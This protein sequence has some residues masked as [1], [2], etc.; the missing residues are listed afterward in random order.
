MFLEELKRADL[1]Y[2]FMYRIKKQWYMPSLKKKKKNQ[3][4]EVTDLLWTTRHYSSPVLFQVCLSVRKFG[5]K[6]GFVFC[7]SNKC[8]WFQRWVDDR[9]GN[10]SNPL[11]VR[12]RERDYDVARADAVQ[13]SWLWRLDNLLTKHDPE[14]ASMIHGFNKKKCISRNIKCWGTNLLITNSFDWRVRS[15]FQ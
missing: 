11:S 6:V 15:Y 2:Y 8:F 9:G 10:Y 1:R 3:E 4:V 13:C 12:E 14:F 5:L 7:R